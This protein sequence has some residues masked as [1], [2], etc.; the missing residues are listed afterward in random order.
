MVSSKG[1]REVFPPDRSIFCDDA[2]PLVVVAKG[3][4]ARTIRDRHDH[5]SLLAT[6]EDGLGLKRLGHAAAATPISGIFS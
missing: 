3:L 5:Y 2:V 4:K 1:L 6:I